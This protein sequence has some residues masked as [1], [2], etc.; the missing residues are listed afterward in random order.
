M[1]KSDAILYNFDKITSVKKPSG[2]HTRMS[3]EEDIMILVEHIKPANVFKKKT[4]RLHNAFPDMKHD[5]LE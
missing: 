3:I 4:G 5:C 1:E 2:R